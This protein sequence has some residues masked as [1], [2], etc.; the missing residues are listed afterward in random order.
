MKALASL[1][2]SLLAGCAGVVPVVPMPPVADLFHDAAFAPPA[3]PIDPAAALA[4]SEAMRGYLASQ[5]GS[6]TRS[7]DR[8]RRLVDALNR[9]DLRLEY[10]SAMTR[11]AAQAFAARSGNCLALVLMTASL[12]KELGLAVGYQAVLGEQAWDR[13]DD[14]DIAIGHV[15]LVL[16]ERRDPFDRSRLTAGAMVVDFLPPRDARRLVTR[17][18]EERTV[19]AMYLNNRAVES[20]AQGQIDDAYGWAREALRT[21]PDMLGAYLTLGVVYRARHLPQAAEQVLRRVLAREPDHLLALSNLALLL[22][23]LGR[24]DE[25]AAITQRLATLDPEPPF[26][27]FR[28]GLAAFREGRFEDARRL[29]AK[30]VARAPG[31]PE[32]EYWL[33]RSHLALNEPTRAA[34]HLTRAMEASTTRKERDLYAAKLDW[35]KA[36]PSP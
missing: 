28:A 1:L 3:V 10:D 13:T 31:R 12:A 30:E 8:R 35:L 21:D 17:P 18:I 25:A 26:S 11:T 16:D 22:H 4:P 36:L 14:L 2:F 9:G 23:D 29:F 34:V 5:Y 24:A 7:T 6:H 19:V 20:L 32:F 33:A 15:N 27:H